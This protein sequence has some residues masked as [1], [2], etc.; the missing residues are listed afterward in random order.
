[1]RREATLAMKSAEKGLLESTSSVQTYPDSVEAA[2]ERVARTHET[3]AA[4]L[5]EFSA[6]IISDSDAMIDFVLTRAKKMSV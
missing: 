4:R 5:R 3:S 1:M 6:T 2:A